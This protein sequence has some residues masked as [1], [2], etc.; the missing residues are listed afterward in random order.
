M[1]SGAGLARLAREA[2]VDGVAPSILAAAGTI[3]AVDGPLVTSLVAGGDAAAAAVLDA[4]AG[5]VALGLLNIVNIVDPEVVVLGGGLVGEGDRL[6]HRISDSF[7]VAAAA[8]GVGPLD[9]RISSVGPSAGAVGAAML[10][11]VTTDDR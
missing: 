3:E 2:V 5:W 1:A 9:L 4:F 11:G 7:D 8:S 10:A 6:L